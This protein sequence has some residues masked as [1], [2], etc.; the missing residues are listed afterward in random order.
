[1]SLSLRGR[2]YT[3]LQYLMFI[4]MVAVIL[5][6]AVFTH[7]LVQERRKH[8]VETADVR[9][10][11]AG[12]M[13]YDLLGS[14]YH[15]DLVDEGSLTPGEFE[16]IVGRND[17]LCR[18]LNLQYL[19]SVLVL[20][21][22]I[23]FTSSTRTDLDD[24]NS[25]YASFFEV[26]RDPQA[27]DPALVSGGEPV[28]STFTNEWGK[29]R[30]VLIPRTDS[31]GRT[32][33]I[34]ASIQLQEFNAM[35]RQAAVTAL[36]LGFLVLIAVILLSFLM[37]RRATN[38]ISRLT[39]SAERMSL[40]DL[41]EPLQ[42][43]GSAEMQSLAG[44]L[45]KMR[46]NLNQ[47]FANLLQARM[48]ETNENVILTR[49]GKRE[50]LE[51][52]LTDIALFCEQ[53]DPKIK[54]SILLFDPKSEALF[55]AAGPSLPD[56]YNDLMKPG[57]PIGPQVGSCGTA[58][59]H[60]KQ[61]VV[62]NIQEDPGWLPYEDFIRVTAKYG[63]KACWSQPFF[64]SRGE[65]L[66][67]IANYSL[68]TGSPTQENKR[69]LDWSTRIAGLAVEQDREEKELVKAKTVAE[70]NDKLKTSF[71]QNMSH[72]I[73]TPLNGI[74]GF[75]GLL[76]N[77]ESLD[78]EQRREYVDIILSS[79]NRLLSIVDDVLE[80]SRIESGLV[81]PR[82]TSFSLGEIMVYLKNLFSLEAKAKGLIFE[83]RI[84]DGLSGQRV[85]SDKD[86]IIQILSNLLGNAVKFT[87]EGAIELH[88]KRD[89]D[90]I[91]FQVRDTGIGIDEKF[92]EK[93]FD[94]FWQHEAFTEEFY[95]GTGLG[96]SISKGLADFLGFRISLDSQK[97]SGSVFSLLLPKSVLLDL[98]DEEEENGLFAEEHL[99][100]LEGKKAL[101]V[102]DDPTSYLYVSEMLKKEGARFTWV[103][104]GKQAVDHVRKESFDFVVMDLKM[105]VMDGLEATRQIKDIRPR[106]FVLIQTAYASP[107]EEE[108]ARQ[109]GADAF[110]T[111]PLKP[112][113]SERFLNHLARWHS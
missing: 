75:S 13:L 35:V 97:G 92:H 108:K 18:R 43:S 31:Q 68:E 86:K 72:E 87:Y 111:K 93:V 9:L 84:Y 41:E 11:T 78:E 83:T 74:M 66:G 65:L 55:H 47:Q 48:R 5:S 102:E 46:M 25:T 96:L 80:L 56:E 52:I 63:L 62:T 44:S 12:K 60:R 42:P 20:D 95:G 34:G 14:N 57:L 30:M 33:I 73:R 24:P 82:L 110:F 58:A 109:A 3:T 49:I 10:L 77:F 19:W 67:T 22:Q 16:R 36:G 107:E 106:L 1:M 61:V 89:G 88:L 59:Y 50:P 112:E 101:I 51:T 27:F 70:Q 105:P 99:R 15:D 76:R 91:A 94:R 104:N 4:V 29:G 54:A 40:G 90:Q 103:T 71:L 53:M 69:V 28:F 2:P 64:S 37:A 26:H 38:S 32:F 100:P 79:S 8:V 6:T 17:A 39:A 23:V 7:L 113:D 85:Y 81:Q 21:D 45:E 98:P